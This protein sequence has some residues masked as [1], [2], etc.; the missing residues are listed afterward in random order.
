MKK[1]ILLVIL[2][3]SMI[4]MASATKPQINEFF[5]NNVTQLTINI[6]QDQSSSNFYLNTN[7]TS[8][9][10]QDIAFGQFTLHNIKISNFLNGINGQIE[11]QE[12]SRIPQF[13]ELKI[14]QDT[15]TSMILDFGFQEF[16]IGFTTL[17]INNNLSLINNYLIKNPLPINSDR[18]IIFTK[19]LNNYTIWNNKGYGDISEN[20]KDEIRKIIKE[21][22]L[23]IDVPSITE[24][25]IP[26]IKGQNLTILDDLD[27]NYTVKIDVSNL[28]LKDGEYIIPIII[29]KDEESFVKN[30]TLILNGIKSIEETNVNNTFIPIIPEIKDLISKINGLGDNRLIISLFD[31]FTSTP[32]NA[33]TIFKYLNITVSNQTNASIYFNL[34]KSEINDPNKVF[35]YVLENDWIKLNTELIN[36]TDFY[37]Y[38]A[39]IPHFSLFSIIEEQIIVS[40][41]SGGSSGGGGGGGGSSSSHREKIIYN[42]PIDKPVEEPPIL[43]PPIQDKPQIQIPSPQPKTD[44]SIF[45]LKVI[46]FILL[47]VLVILVAIII[48]KSRRN[49]NEFK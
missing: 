45:Y 48:L 31:N 40:P 44:N 15:L 36:D 26:L 34:N 41:P 12:S 21:S 27:L 4:G 2:L 13:N 39:D 5:N 19:A 17:D 8:F 47:G 35:L 20:F 37:Y 46:L 33:K 18:H 42:P 11:V 7:Q 9:D 16:N 30:V 32:N 29:E 28:I 24:Q 25:F 14:V 1:L 49:K 3:I 43:I 23:S 22:I 38:K 10:L 6:N